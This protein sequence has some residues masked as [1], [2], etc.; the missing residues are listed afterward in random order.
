VGGTTRSFVKFDLSALPAGLGCAGVS[1]ASLILWAGRVPAAG[2]VQLSEVSAA[3]D[4]STLTY[5]LA[6]AAGSV[7]TTIPVSQASEFVVVDA[8]ASVQ[9]WL[10]NRQSNQ[11]FVLSTTGAASVFF[12]SK[13]SVTTSHA[14]TLELM[15]KAGAGATGSTGATGAAGPTGDGISAYG[16]V[17]NLIDQFVALEAD[18]TFDTNGGL[19]GGITHTAGASTIAVA[20]A[21]EYEIDFGVSADGA[22]QLTVFVN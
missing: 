4:E 21:G 10:Q 20:S 2:Q 12:D 1:K 16:Y 22:K 6:S 7:I 5:A 3:W 18:I 17:Y 14:P 15:V 8:T 11:G 13:E 19:F 9:K